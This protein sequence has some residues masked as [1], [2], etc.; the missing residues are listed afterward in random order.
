MEVGRDA[1]EGLLLEHD[2][3]PWTCHQHVAAV[4]L[5]GTP[6]AKGDRNS[7][8]RLGAGLF[9]GHGSLHAIRAALDMA[10][11]TP[12]L[13]DPVR[14][15]SSSNVPRGSCQEVG[16]KSVVLDESPGG[17]SVILLWA[18]R[19]LRG[20]DGFSSGQFPV[21]IPVHSS[22]NPHTRVAG[23]CLAT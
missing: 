13:A 14:V 8:N 9:S 15:A 17:C 11:P 3:N 18:A 5:S 21:P 6:R 20:W 23:L 10:T 19:H 2:S 4:S 22:V 16:G 7:P 1:L 12:D